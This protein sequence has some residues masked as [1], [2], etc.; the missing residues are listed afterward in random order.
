MM[1][2]TKIFGGIFARALDPSHIFQE[3]FNNVYL[4]VVLSCVSMN[5]KASHSSVAKH[6]PAHS[7]F[8]LKYNFIESTIC[9]LHFKLWKILMNKI[10]FAKY[11]I[12]NLL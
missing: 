11:D 10:D 4:Q 3:I 7:T 5:S 8:V 1:L 12:I 9:I 2:K 6:C